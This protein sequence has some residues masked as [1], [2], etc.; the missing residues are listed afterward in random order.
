MFPPSVAKG[1]RVAYVRQ[2]I[3]K[4]PDI[5]GS[6]YHFEILWIRPVTRATKTQIL[7]GDRRFLKET[8]LEH[9]RTGPFPQEYLRPVTDR[10]VYGPAFTAF[11]RKVDLA[12]RLHLKS[13]SADELRALAAH[14]GV[15]VPESLQTPPEHPC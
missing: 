7:V 11:A 12:F 4:E 15:P 2:S 13:A 9:P 3:L 10:L 1:D 8:G 14:L 6:R 5:S